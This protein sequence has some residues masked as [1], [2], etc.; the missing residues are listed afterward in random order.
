MQRI[1]KAIS[2]FF[3][4]R[5]RVWMPLTLGLFLLAVNIVAARYAALVFGIAFQGIYLIAFMAIQVI[6]WIGIFFYVLAGRV[7]VQVIMPGDLNYTWD[8]YR[9][10]PE[11]VKRAK[12]WVDYLK[13][14][15]TFEDMG[16]EFVGGLLFE[17]GPG[18]GKTYLAKIIA[19][20]AGIPFMSIEANSLMGT[21]V[22]IGPLKVTQ[23]FRR[24]RNLADE[25]GGSILYIDEIDAIGA[26]RTGPMSP[27]TGA[28][29]ADVHP[30]MM[31]A[32]MN[33]GGGI[34]N[35]L[36]TELDGF[37]EGR[38]FFWRLRKR[39][40]TWFGF[41]GPKWTVPRVMV[42]GSTNRPDILDPAL[43]RPGRLGKRIVIDLPSPEG[44]EDIA[45]YYLSKIR[46]DETLSPKAIARDSMNQTPN[47]VRWALND[48]VVLAH[49]EG[50][51]IVSYRH[52]RTAVSEMILG[53]KQPL[54]LKDEDK[55]AIAV[56]E[57]GHAAMVLML[58]EGEETVELA[59]IDRYGGQTLG[60]IL[61][62]PV[63]IRFVK[64]AERLA[65]AI[66]VSMAGMAAE[67]VFLGQ[68]NASAGGDL[69]NILRTLQGMAMHGMFSVWP[70]E[71]DG[72]GDL[73]KEIS[74]YRRRMYDRAKSLLVT[75]RE[76]ILHLARAL[77]ERREL[78]GPEIEE[79]WNG[80]EKGQEEVSG[81]QETSP[82]AAGVP[83]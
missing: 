11:L 37:R 57:A 45:Q 21:F 22:G 29:P 9:G 54:P 28:Q 62:V 78:L 36:L 50:K 82:A 2:N 61:P 73:R 41:S 7:R 43:V 64:S 33:M 19:A 68:R 80:H 3:K 51:D 70:G 1:K 12:A 48:A 14:V 69:P 26:S 49:G 4:Y 44:L 40:L 10:Q 74:S 31:G 35:T 6:A 47:T 24:V 77:M 53:P 5:K 13:G 76:R 81:E 30:Q 46:H 18:T 32:G 23:L 71:S 25:F 38:G 17:G 8:D 59:T 20:E 56:H 16:G 63:D 65:K 79:I 75:N 55:W 66:T 58:L 60:H 52:W 34:L 67:E 39:F 27:V 15:A 72:D 83:A 42:I